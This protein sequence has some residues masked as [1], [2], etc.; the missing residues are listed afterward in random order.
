[1]PSTGFAAAAVILAGGLST[2]FG[3]DKA[4]EPLGGVPL[5][6]RVIDRFAG[7]VDE[8]IVVCRTGQLLPALT[9]HVRVIVD[10]SPGS[11][12]LGGLFTGL[13]ACNAHLVVAVACD[14][15]LL[16]PDLIR[17]LLDRGRDRGCAVP[18]ARGQ[19]Q[20]LC[21]VYSKSALEPMRRR[22]ESG[23][24]KLTDLLEDLDPYIMSEGEWLPL[25]AAG[26][27]FL[28]LNTPKDFA[29]AASL[30]EAEERVSRSP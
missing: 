23:R 3:R 9:R 11:G 29:R 5:L 26:L 30:L 27:S 18:V 6:Q 1:M 19:A 10:A 15:P 13:A 14:M 22:I 21:A 2:R 4:S 25:D 24:L 28:N 17:A 12:P 7:L 16:Q 20:P 8:I